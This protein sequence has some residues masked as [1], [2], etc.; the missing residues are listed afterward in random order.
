MYPS[1]MVYFRYIVVNTLHKSHNKD[2]NNKN[3]NN[4]MSL[5]TT[6]VTF[7]TLKIQALYSAGPGN[8]SKYRLKHPAFSLYI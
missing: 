7:T 2:D 8:F 3:I 5:Y 4:N 1:N 6:S